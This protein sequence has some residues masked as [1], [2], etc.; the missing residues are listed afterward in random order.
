MASAIDRKSQ[1]ATSSIHPNAGWR[2]GSL[3]STVVL[4]EHLDVFSQGEFG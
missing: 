3:L 1:W 4:R 2:H